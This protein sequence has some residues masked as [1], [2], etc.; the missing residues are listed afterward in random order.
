MVRPQFFFWKMGTPMQKNL[1]GLFRSLLHGI[2]RAS[3]ELGPFIFPEFWQSCWHASSQT[4]K[5]ISL[6]SRS[7][8]EA[9]DRLLSDAALCE[10]YRFCLFL[11][12]LDEYEGTEGKDHGDLVKMLGTWTATAQDF[13]KL[14]VSSREENV[15]MNAFSSEQRIRIHDLTRLDMARYAASRRYLLRWCQCTRKVNTG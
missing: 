7:I 13:V 4:L 15:F 8:Q 12:G 9:F 5:S 11:D 3:P 6:S 1:D 14:F 10:S 2:L